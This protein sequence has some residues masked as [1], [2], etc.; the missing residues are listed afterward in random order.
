M[1]LS[2]VSVQDRIASGEDEYTEFKRKIG[3]DLSGVG[4]TLC[5]F[6]N[7]PGGLLVIGLDDAGDVIDGVEDSDR[8]QERLTSFLESGCNQ[9]IS[10]ELG[11][12]DLDCGWIHWVNVQRHQRKTEPF[13]YKGEYW[14]RRGR[15]SVA[16]SPSERQ[17]L[18]NAFGFVMTEEQVITSAT[19]DAIDLESF[20]SFMRSQGLR[21]DEE[22]ILPTEVDMCNSR[23]CAEIDGVLRPTLFGLMVFGKAPQLHPYTTSFFIQCAAYAGLDQAAAELSVAEG[24][25]RLDEQVDRALDW[26]RSLGHRVTYEG[27]LRT[28]IPLIPQDVLREAL[29]NA[30]IHRD[31]A[32]IGGRVHLDVFLDRITV[33]S[34]GSLPNHMT[35]AQACGGGTPRSRNEMM[36]N[37]MVVRRRMERRGRGWP[38]MCRRMREFNG[39][40]PTMVNIKEGGFVRVTFDLTPSPSADDD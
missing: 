11:R 15:S 38:M 24:R 20:L 16:S 26:F 1:P 23:V 19:T 40:E 29:V 2:F 3:R 18:F 5:A 12:S 31:Y 37:A 27:I 13:R 17:E 25:G 36:A 21:P 14:I 6:A 32:I 10:A 8:I 7:G 4:K 34:Q 33:T 39:T 30:V 22:P 28:D 9:P 35:V